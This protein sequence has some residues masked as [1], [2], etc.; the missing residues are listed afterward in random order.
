METSTLVRKGYGRNCLH[1]D[2]EVLNNPVPPPQPPPPEGS[3]RFSQGAPLTRA[4]VCAHLTQELIAS[5][6]AI[7][8]N[9]KDVHEV[10]YVFNHS[11][12]PECASLR[13]RSHLPRLIALALSVPPPVSRIC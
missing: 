12:T 4:R 8:L 6:N 9:H 3:G 10:N 1:H 11:G 7:V 2:L 5:G 13:P